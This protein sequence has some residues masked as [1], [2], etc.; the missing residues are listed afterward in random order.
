[1]SVLFLTPI[2]VIN[3]MTLINVFIVK[4]YSKYDVTFIQFLTSDFN[5]LIYNYSD[6]N[7]LRVY[8][9]LFI[10]CKN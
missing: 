4:K 10:S 2:D 3:I 1:M 7:Y 8:N 9:E 5:H 6:Q